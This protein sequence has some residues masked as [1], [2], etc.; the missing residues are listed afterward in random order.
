M[1]SPCDQFFACA[2]FTHDQ[3]AG[4]CR[5]G[6]SDLFPYS[7]YFGA[8]SEDCVSTEETADRR[9]QQL[10]LAEQTGALTSAPD[11]CPYNLWIERLC[12]EIESSLPHALHRKLDGWDSS[13]ED[14]RY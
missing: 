5:G 6:A 7:L 9:F 4:V 13:E 3:H 11:G 12:Y 14:D 2:G 1:N 8:V 10:I